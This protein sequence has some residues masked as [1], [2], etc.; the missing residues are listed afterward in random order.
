[1]LGSNPPVMRE[2]YMEYGG[3]LGKDGFW[4]SEYGIVSDKFGLEK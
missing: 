4:N 2:G 3:Y 1:M